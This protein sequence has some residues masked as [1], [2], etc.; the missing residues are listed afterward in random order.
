MAERDDRG[1]VALQFLVA[2]AWVGFG[3]W[4]LLL[5]V[6]GSFWS[7]GTACGNECNDDISRGG[8]TLLIGLS[9]IFGLASWLATHTT[10]LRRRPVILG[11]GAVAATL[12]TAAVVVFMMPE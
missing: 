5:L 2:L 12:C 11:W 6:V 1:H 9:F 8:W 7:F 3:I 4:S 10:D